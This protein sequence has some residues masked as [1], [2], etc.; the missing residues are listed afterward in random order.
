MIKKCYLVYAIE[1]VD[2]GFGDA[3]ETT[4]PLEVFIRKEEAEQY[5]VDNNK[6]YVYDTPYN[7]LYTGGVGM[8]ELDLNE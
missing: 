8:M 6:P 1:D 7:E 4:E 5:V 2:G 3:V